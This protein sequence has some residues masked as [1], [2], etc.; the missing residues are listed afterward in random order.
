[1]EANWTQDVKIPIADVLNW[2]IHGETVSEA[3][4]N[5]AGFLADIPAKYQYCWRCKSV[6]VE[7]ENLIV[8]LYA[9]DSDIQAPILVCSKCGK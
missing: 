1:M 8:H 5:N 7:G 4:A 6:D 3:A 2:T 9:F